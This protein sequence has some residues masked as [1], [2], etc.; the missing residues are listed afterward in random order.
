MSYDLMHPKAPRLSGALLEA[1]A[2]FLERPSLGKPLANRLLK[3]TGIDRFRHLHAPESPRLHPVA[4]GDLSHPPEP[5]VLDLEAV[6]RH[7]SGSSAP[8]EGGFRYTTIREYAEAYRRGDTTPTEVCEGI[9]R[10]LL[11][12]DRGDPPLYLF[13]RWNEEKIRAQAAESTRRYKEGKPRSILEGV[14]V[15]VKDELNV[16]GFPTSLG[17]SF[18]TTGAADADAAVVARLRAAGAVI[19]GKANMHEIGMG[20]TGLNPNYGTP[21]NPYAPWRYPGGSSSGSAAAVALGMAPLAVGADGG[22]S[23]RIPAAFCGVAG[24]KP[25][26]GRVSGRG[27]LP[28][29][30]SVA[31]VGPIAGS[32]EDLA[33]SYAVMAGREAKDPWSYRQPHLTLE[34][35][36]TSIKGL[37]LGLYV[38]WFE[39]ADDDIL[40]VV[41]GALAAVEEAGAELVEVDI[42][43]L[44]NLRVAH[45]ITISTEQRAAMDRYYKDHRTDFG[46]ETRANLALAARLT[47]SDYIKAQQMRERGLKQWGR[48]FEQVDAVVTPTTAVL[49]PKVPEDRL[50][51]GVSDLETLSE[52]MRFATPANLLGYPAIS[53]P[54]GFVTAHSRR[55]SHTQ[56]ERDH[57]GQVYSSVPAGIQFIAPYYEEW[58]LLRLAAAVEAMT[59]RPEPRV[60]FP[61]LP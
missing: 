10:T 43:E 6:A 61:S 47:G 16:A 11:E 39:D 35:A 23:I 15:P 29:C 1:A 36:P 3:A 57:Q 42:P 33:V 19:L 5:S 17:T 20:V 49:P 59:P 38:P 58:R 22:G 25:T 4:P 48:V 51:S 44:E 40:E 31:H 55:F 53:V 13:V 2:A 45:L 9:I 52:I 26:F 7:F 34:E 56:E 8:A 30:W 32:V 27:A 50:L 18:L 46:L 54:A 14:P 28:V 41:R 21:I 37:K 12:Q 60:Y 24:L